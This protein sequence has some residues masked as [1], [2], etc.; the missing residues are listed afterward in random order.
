MEA[1]QERSRSNPQANDCGEE[2]ALALRTQ[3]NSLHLGEN[4]V[5][6]GVWLLALNCAALGE[7][8]VDVD[9]FDTIRNHGPSML[10]SVSLSSKCMEREAGQD[11][12]V[13][14]VNSQGR[15]FGGD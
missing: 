13:M 11:E 12:D 2:A 6:P 10:F 9:V 14:V 3:H 7:T 5:F 15:V 8:R 4:A 1:T